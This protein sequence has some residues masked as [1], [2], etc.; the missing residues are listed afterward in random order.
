MATV[1]SPVA[2]PQAG[3]S[4]FGRIIGVFF[5][6][7]ATFE[8]IVR[9]PSWIPP[10]IVLFLTGML[11]NLTLANHANWTEVSRQQ[12]DKNKWVASQIDRLDDSK[13]AQAFERAAAQAKI[14]RYVR[15]LIG[16]PLALLVASVLY[17]GAYRLIGGA[18]LSFGVAGVIVAFANLPVALKEILGALVTA[19]RDP[20][21]IDPE[22]Y[23]ASNPAALMGPDTPTWQMIPLAFLDIFTIWALVLVAVGFAAADPKKLPFGKSLGIAIGVNLSLMAVFTM[24]AWVFS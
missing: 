20:N 1:P 2:E 18:R 6:P 22:N 4:P 9:K 23:I 10:L 5:S 16:W 14:F 12:I 3:I 8:G 19:L 21:A 11:L 24:I 7:K 15:A 17:F 13:K